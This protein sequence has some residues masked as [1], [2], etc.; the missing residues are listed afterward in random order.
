MITSRVAVGAVAVLLLWG[1]WPRSAPAQRPAPDEAIGRAQWLVTRNPADGRG[2]YRLGDAYIQKARE[3]GDITYFTLAEESLR[4]ALALDPRDGAAARHL[5]FTLYSRHDFAGALAEAQR[6]I[7]LRPTDGYAYGILGDA[8]QEVGRYDEAQSA[9]ARMMAIAPDFYA[10]SRRSGAKS[11]HGDPDGAVADLA[12][13]IELGQASRQPRESVAWAQWQLANEELAQGHVR[14]AETQHLAALETYPGYH[15]ALAGLGEVR[16]AEGRYADAID[17]FRRAI[18]VIPMPGYA[19][20]LGDAYAKTGARREAERQYALV[21]YI[22]RLNSLNTVLYNR[23]LAYFYADH[24]LKLGDSLALARH[25]LLVRQDVY[26]YDVLAWAL[27]KNGRTAEAAA[28]IAQARRL[29][30]RDARLWYHAGMIHH[31]L[32]EDAAARADLE[33]ALAINPRFHIFHADLAARTLA[34]IRAR[35]ASADP[36][37]GDRR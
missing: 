31:R 22:G 36:L 35:A 5:A 30:T 11:I 20:A 16:V 27:Y 24:D 23:E 3:S 13:A 28:A 14:E 7:A 34:Q 12:R 18:A 1:L 26:A 19:A 4:K 25:E 6:A 29:G 21:E 37:P 9:Y 2:Y 15:R 33:G 32:G 8:Y 10:Y 17:L